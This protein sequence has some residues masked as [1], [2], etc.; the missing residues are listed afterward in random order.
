MYVG[1]RYDFTLYC[2]CYLVMKFEIAMLMQSVKLHII[3]VHCLSVACVWR[4]CMLCEVI[5]YMNDVTG[6]LPVLA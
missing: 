3:Y 1:P 6:K 5:V 4:S 2:T